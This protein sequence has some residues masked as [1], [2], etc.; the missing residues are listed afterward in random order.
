MYLPGTLPFKQQESPKKSLKQT[1]TKSLNDLTVKPL[2]E[3]RGG[4][5]EASQPLGHSPDDCNG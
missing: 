5:T 3:K 1:F 4:D 2:T